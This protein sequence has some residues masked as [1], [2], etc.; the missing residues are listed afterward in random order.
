MTAEQTLK[1]IEQSIKLARTM[2]KDQ[3]NGMTDGL[4]SALTLNRISRS[5]REYKDGIV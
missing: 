3:S 5:V 2:A 4:I 1:Q